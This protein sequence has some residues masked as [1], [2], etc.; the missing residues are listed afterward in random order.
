MLPI[1]FLNAPSN[2]I[3]QFGLENDISPL[4]LEDC[5]SMGQR[6]KFEDYDNHQFLVWF[7]NIAGKATEFHFLIL[8]EKLVLITNTHPPKQNTWHEYL[9]IKVQNQSMT[10]ILYSYL[11]KLMDLSEQYAEVLFNKILDMEEGILQG[12]VNLDSIVNIKWKLTKLEYKISPLSLVVTHWRD[13]LTLDNEQAW[14]IR[15]LLDHTLRLDKSLKFHIDQTENA[16]NMYWGKASDIAN[17]RMNH[18]TIVAFIF[19]PLT[20]WTSFWGMNFTAIPWDHPHFFTLSMIVLMT[21]PIGAFLYL[22]KKGIIYPNHLKKNERSS[23][24]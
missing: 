5:I 20:F 14:H 2:E 16:I 11:D 15:D 17:S 18:L 23:K 9:N 8:K 3:M 24:K 10:T 22:K 7:A 6:S 1:E 21:S 13:F 19:F 4:A 12:K